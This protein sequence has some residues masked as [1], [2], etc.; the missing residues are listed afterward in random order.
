MRARL[1]FTLEMRRLDPAGE[2]LGSDACVF[3]NEVGERV[4][5]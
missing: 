1:V 2:E 4:T 5:S 3:G